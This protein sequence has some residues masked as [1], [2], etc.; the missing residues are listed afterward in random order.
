MTQ[1]IN[2]QFGVKGVV[3]AFIDCTN[4]R[5]LTGLLSW[6]AEETIFENT[7]P[8]PDGTRY[9]GREAARAFWEDFFASSPHARF[10]EEELLEAGEHCIFRWRYIWDENAGKAGYIRGIDLF[11]VHEGK[12]VEKLSYVKG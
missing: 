10:E 1:E 11:H 8:P 7:F 2:Q 3:Q 6:L 5:D 4:R 9:E 12:I